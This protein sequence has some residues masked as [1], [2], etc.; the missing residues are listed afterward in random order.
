MPSIQTQGEAWRSLLQCLGTRASNRDR[1]PWKTGLN[2]ITDT[3]STIQQVILGP[4]QVVSGQ[5]NQDT[6]VLQ[7]QV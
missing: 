2:P 1:L 7:V 3:A 4:S 5:E 6:P